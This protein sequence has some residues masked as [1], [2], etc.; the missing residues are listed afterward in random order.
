MIS[1][2]V[3]LAYLTR[4]AFSF[5]MNKIS[6][7]IDSMSTLDHFF[8]SYIMRYSF[9]FLLVL[10][11]SQNVHADC[12]QGDCKN[13]KGIYEY[14]SGARYEGEFVNGELHGYGIFYYTNGNRYEG[15]WEGNYKNGEGKMFYASG[16]FYEGNW[17]RDRRTGHGEYTFKNGDRY[18]GEWHWDRPNGEGELRFV[19]GAHY[20]GGFKNGKF[21]GQ[22]TFRDAQGKIYSGEWTEGKLPGFNTP[23]EETPPADEV[24]KEEPE[25]AE[26]ASGDEPADAI[27]DEIVAEEENADEGTANESA[28]DELEGD[29][30]TGPRKPVEPNWELVRDCFMEKCMEGLGYIT[31]ASGSRYFGSFVNGVPEGEGTCFY[32]NGDIYT[33]GWINNRPEGEG[34]MFYADGR[35]LSAEWKAGK[36]VRVIE[37]KV[38]TVEQPKIK[39]EP[40]PVTRIWAVLVGVARYDHLPALKYSDD[41]AWRMYAFLKSPEGGA[42]PDEQIRILIDEDATR[43]KILDNI[44]STFAKADDNDVVL[45]YMSGHGTQGDFAPIDFDGYKNALSYRE[46]NDLLTS[47]E[48]RHKVVFADACYAGSLLGA[49]GTTEEQIARLYE[50]LSNTSDGVAFML[51][52]KDAEISLEDQGLRQGVYSHFLMRG[53]KGEA[54]EDRDGLVS[55][56]E[57]FHFVYNGVRKYTANAQ[58]PVLAGQFDPS[59]PVSSV[60]Y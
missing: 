50:S 42:L 20:I 23:K 12:V 9:V 35:I 46:I 60:R 19:N 53:M 7:P 37:R 25:T 8:K 59:M 1:V 58:T 51:S 17:Y 38:E 43:E 18:I 54:D 6:L 13:G 31:Y 55:L 45:L 5:I 21:H 30:E 16:E 27:Q 29:V 22:G 33:G 52:S 14:S 39:R 47:S 32:S 24:V 10:T 15:Y 36:T 41:D 57:L 4:G 40:D 28:S 11:I 56:K 48:A 3:L 34:T 44:R 2:N 26:P 49:R